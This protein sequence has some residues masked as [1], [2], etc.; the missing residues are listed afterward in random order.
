MFIAAVAHY[1]VFSHTPFVNPDLP[2]YPCWASFRSMFDVSDV[3]QDMTNHVRLVG[4]SVKDTMLRT[5]PRKMTQNEK[6]RLLDNSS[7]AA[8]AINE[9][10]DHE[11][12]H[13]I[14]DNH[15]NQTNQI[16]AEE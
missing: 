6:V 10:Y 3:R 15:N 4:R 14:E 1:Y 2:S 9:M 5:M 16:T 7:N 8:P 11:H 13:V 12:A